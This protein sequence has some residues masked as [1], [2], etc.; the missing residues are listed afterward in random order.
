MT[1]SAFY[2]VTQTAGM[3]RDAATV[4]ELVD[5]AIGP[6]DG[7]P[8][9]LREALASYLANGDDN[10]YAPLTKTETDHLAVAQERYAD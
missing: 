9:G 8:S 2:G 10:W 3:D 6:W 5:H 1:S 7:P 4:E